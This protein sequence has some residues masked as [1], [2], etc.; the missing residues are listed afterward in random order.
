MQ[1]TPH[2]KRGVSEWS[3]AANPPW[4]QST[5]SSL[6]ASGSEVADSE[7][8]A[9]R[10][11]WR[12]AEARYQEA[13]RQEGREASAAACLAESMNR[14]SPAN[15]LR[16]I[17][18]SVGTTLPEDADFKEMSRRYMHVVSDLATSPAN[19][20]PARRTVYIAGRPVQVHHARA[21][22]AS[23]RRGMWSHA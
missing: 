19:W 4:L 6:A 5:R 9:G 7:G 21:T 16:L 3:A 8:W 1:P 13:W 17:P 11:R 22:C 15:P 2:A 10:D 12:Q 18:R 20:V 23:L 14:E